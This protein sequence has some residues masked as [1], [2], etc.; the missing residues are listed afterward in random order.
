MNLV[1]EKKSD[2]VMKN[3]DSITGDSN[4]KN[5]KGKKKSRSKIEF[6]PTKDVVGDGET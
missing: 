6:D 4:E 5:V 2:D 1:K 3:N